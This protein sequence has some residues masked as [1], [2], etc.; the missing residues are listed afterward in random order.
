[1]LNCSKKNGCSNEHPSQLFSLDV[2]RRLGS[3]TNYF[4]FFF[5]AAFFFVAIECLLWS[6]EPQAHFDLGFCFFCQRSRITF[7]ILRDSICIVNRK[8]H[9]RS[10]HEH[11]VIIMKRDAGTARTIGYAIGIAAAIIVMLWRLALHVR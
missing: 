3:A 11:D 6:F 5:L 9:A 2:L 10:Q 7:M 1:V 8:M 4:F